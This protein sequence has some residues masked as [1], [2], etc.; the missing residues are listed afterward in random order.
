MS[1]DLL[2]CTNVTIKLWQLYFW[3]LCVFFALVSFTWSSVNATQFIS[4]FRK[5][6]GHVTEPVHRSNRWSRE[7]PGLMGIPC[8]FWLLRMKILNTVTFRTHL[9]LLATSFFLWTIKI[10]VDPWGPKRVF[11]VSTFF[12]HTASGHNGISVQDCC[13]KG[14]AFTSEAKLSEGETK[15]L[16]F[17][18]ETTFANVWA[19]SYWPAV[20][21]S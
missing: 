21:T 4:Y 14:K 19:H 18:A 9:S 12:D 10:A 7:A 8:Q 2:A 20:F 11:F 13:P 3:N 6:K 1:R 16:F 15:Y 17:I 5:P